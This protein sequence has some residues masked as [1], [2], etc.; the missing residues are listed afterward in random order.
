[1]SCGLLSC[2]FGTGKRSFGMPAQDAY[3]VLDTAFDGVSDGTLVY[4]GP[5]L[6]NKSS[7]GYGKKSPKKSPKRKS[8]RSLKKS[9]K[10]VFRKISK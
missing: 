7:C 9:P 1:M 10:R 5:N 8:K 4:S 6:L 2:G 3:Q